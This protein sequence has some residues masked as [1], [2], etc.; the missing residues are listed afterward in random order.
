ME[1]VDSKSL[2]LSA[3]LKDLPIHKWDTDIASKLVQHYII[4]I[5]LYF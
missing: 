5:F 1:S 2:Q 3:H 4:I